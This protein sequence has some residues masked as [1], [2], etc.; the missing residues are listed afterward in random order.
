M[1]ARF[2]LYPNGQ[3]PKN[4]TESGI[5]TDVKRQEAK[6]RVP[7]LF[8]PLGNIGVVGINERSK[9]PS[10]IFTNESGKVTDLIPKH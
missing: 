10:E 3:S 6:L 8:R 1:E 5:V 4:V 7:I 2:L 9:A